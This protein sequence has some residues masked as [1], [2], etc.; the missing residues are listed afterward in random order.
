MLTSPDRL[1]ADHDD[2]GLEMLTHRTSL[3]RP[4]DAVAVTV[5]VAAAVLA[6]GIGVVIIGSTDPADPSAPSAIAV[7]A[8]DPSE[9]PRV[10]LAAAP[11]L[12]VADTADEQM[13]IDVLMNEG[14]AL[15]DQEA[16]TAILLLREEVEE[17]GF[18]AGRQD[19]IRAQVRAFLPRLDERQGE[20][21]VDC[22]V[23]AGSMLV[24]HNGG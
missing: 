8:Q 14:L 5:C 10:P 11:A 7:A 19:A 4:R 21:V 24:A 13:Y 1:A 9:A 6:S 2:R 20:V 12:F 15:S 3:S 22:I 18:I 23:K 17:G 16:R